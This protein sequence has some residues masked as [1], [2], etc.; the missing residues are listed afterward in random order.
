MYVR[1]SKLPVLA[2]NLNL[3]TLNGFH[4]MLLYDWS[5]ICSQ[6]DSISLFT[7]ET[8]QNENQPAKIIKVKAKITKRTNPNLT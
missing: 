6:S 2:D 1:K 8:M 7:N 3:D 4:F 5:L